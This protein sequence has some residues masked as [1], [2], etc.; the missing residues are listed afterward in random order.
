MALD[1]LIEG[2][3]RIAGE[4][5]MEVIFVRIFYWPGWLILRT[6]TLGRYPPRRSNP[7]SEEFVAT[8]GLLGVIACIVLV[9]N[10]AG[11]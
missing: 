11:T 9:V 6:L 7:H 2:A 3:L 8:M 10:R 4:F 5:F 1:A